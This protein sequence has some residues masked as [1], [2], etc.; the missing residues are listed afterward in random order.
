MNLEEV[1]DPKVEDILIQVDSEGYYVNCPWLN[2]EKIGVQ[3]GCNFV[4]GQ[5]CKNCMGKKQDG[6]VDYIQCGYQSP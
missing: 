5:G 2:G 4:D 3:S 1:D 6:D